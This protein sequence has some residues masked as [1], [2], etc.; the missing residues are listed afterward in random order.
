ME[1]IRING[2]VPQA[3]QAFNPKRQIISSFI[4]GLQCVERGEMEIL[5]VGN[6]FEGSMTVVTSQNAGAVLDEMRSRFEGEYPDLF[7]AEG[8]TA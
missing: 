1:R 5:G 2:D 6:P 3:E 7:A 4:A 8:A